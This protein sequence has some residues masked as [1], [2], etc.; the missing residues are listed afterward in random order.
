MFQEA[1]VKV[2]FGLSIKEFSSKMQNASRQLDK[3]GKQFNKAGKKMSM[4]LTLPLTGLAAASVKAFDTQA[5]AIAQ[6]EAGLRSTGNQVGY[7]SRQLQKMASDLQG[8]SL[9]GDED[10][11]KDVT[12]QL[13]T[14]TN[15]SGAQFAKTQ[16]AAL[17]LATRLDGD[18]KSASIMLGK[19]LNDPVAN[20]S[21]L[22][23]AG[24]QF[25][26]EQKNMVKSLV[27][28]NQIAKA[29]D[30]ILEEL[31]KQYGGSAQA[32]AQAGAG[33]LKQMNMA[34]GD[35]MESFGEVINDMIIPLAAKV[36]SLSERFQGLSYST[37]KFIV[38]GAGIAAAMGPVLMIIGQMSFGLA[39]LTRATAGTV[40]AVASMSRAFMAMAVN[41]ITIKI[42][43][44]V[45]AIA[46][47]G[48]AGKYVYDNWDAF[49][50]RFKMLWISIKNSVISA[51]QGVISGLDKLAGYAGLSFFEGV[52]DS[53]ESLKE[54]LPKDQDI[55]PFKSFMETLSGLKESLSGMMDFGGLFGSGGSGGVKKQTEEFVNVMSKGFQSVG[56]KAD[57]LRTKLM[58]ITPVLKEMGP[59]AE[60]I[61]EKQAAA[62]DNM[63]G[64]VNGLG[65]AFY[66]MFE[67]MANNS[68]NA[69][70]AVIT[71]LKRLVLRLVSAVA[72]AGVLSLLL[73]GISP[74]FAKA[75]SFK[76]LFN[77]FSGMNIKGFAD[78]GSPPLNRVSLVGERGPELF[79]PRQSGIVVPNHALGGRSGGGLSLDLGGNFQLS[80]FD[81]YASV[82]QVKERRKRF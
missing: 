79:V 48:L 5:K 31:A 81:L 59:T 25:S 60:Q 66:Q 57:E 45:A 23:R 47:L 71:Y 56:L 40:K 44:I 33:G 36:K 41:P 7:T 14:F 46:A 73:G 77:S 58:G 27:A 68:Q 67:A 69:F 15:I 62:I 65:D 37:R 70:Q 6:V 64:V 1:Q 61:A 24:I 9:F 2:K 80:G 17:D 74:A 42:G 78:G 11:L 39:A 20:L 54:E 49:A 3:I 21:A 13:L 16:Q 32:A 26:E 63:R 28:T 82:S 76:N 19:A 22:S 8:V 34:I 12:A 43:L 72:A 35:L 18:L 51:I 29:Q 75:F 53:L 38:I 30:L 4:A 52:A 55:L 50:Q 10:I